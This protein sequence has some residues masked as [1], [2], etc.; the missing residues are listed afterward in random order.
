MDILLAA[1]YQMAVS[2]IFHIV[3]ACI[4][5]AMPWLMFVAEYKWIKT[6]EQSILLLP[7]PGH[8]ELP[9]FL[10]WELFPEPYYHLSWDYYGQNSWNM[11]APSLACHSHGKELPFFL[12]LLLLGFPVWMEQ[13]K[14]MG[15][16][17]LRSCCRNCRCSIR[18]FRGVG[19]CLDEQP[20]RIRLGKRTG[21]QY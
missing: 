15:T 8:A 13:G 2:F 19:Q 17:D 11:P 3:F 14:Q 6:G 12:K 21:N 16:S 18:H 5:M 1:R 7:K 10:L 9:F 4:G 20:C